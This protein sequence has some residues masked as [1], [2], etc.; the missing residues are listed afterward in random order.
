MLSPENRTLYTSALTPPPGMRFKEAIA[1]TFSLDPAFLLQAPVHL[2]LMATDAQQGDDLFSR[3]EAIRRYADNITVYVQQG[4]IQVPAKGKPSPLFGMLEKMIIEVSAP[5]GGVFHPKIWAIRFADEY[6]D[7]VMYRLVIL[8]RNLTTDASWDLSLQL[9]GWLTGR[10]HKINN[11]LAHLIQLLPELCTGNCDET[12]RDQALRFASELQRVDWQYPPGFD[13][14]AFYLPGIKRFSWKPPQASRVAV[15]SPFC[16]DKALQYIVDGYKHIDAL[17]SRPETLLALKSETRALFSR[18]LHLD[19]AA[20]NPDVP[21][22]PGTDAIT[23][24]GLHAK[25]LLFETGWDSEIVLGSANATNAALLCDKNCEILVSLKG[26][27]SKIGSIGDM[28]SAE[29]MGKYLVDFDESQQAEPDTQRAEAERVAENARSLLAQACLNVTCRPGQ[30]EQAWALIL[31][32]AI[33]PLP[34]IVSGWIWPV[35]V[36]AESGCALPLNAL[37]KEL[38]LGEFSAASLTGLIAFELHTS[39][40]EVTVRFVLNLPLIAVPDER[41]A[42]ILQT[43]INRQEDFMRYL[44]MLLNADSPFAFSTEINADPVNGFYGLSLGEEVPL[45]EEL[46]RMYSRNPERLADVAAL[47]KNLRHSPDKPIP[48]DFLE[49]WAVFESATGVHREQ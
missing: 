45:L 18:T 7:E 13:E 43:I 37:D 27:K 41:E 17:I 39:H 35:T 33:P 40:P 6:E 36:P 31:S 34:G 4:R 2:A 16:S 24:T 5:N 29:G 1:T 25:V 42:M 9:E 48:E 8:S 22:A 10:R 47:V 14:I 49:L 32:G 30:N 26:K 12:R 46:T 19:D 23:A 20:E 38:V 28:L 15:I 3:F 44:M 11:P 21:E